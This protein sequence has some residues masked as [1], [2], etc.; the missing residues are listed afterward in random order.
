MNWIVCLT[1]ICLRS[2]F[3]FQQ[4]EIKI[5][6][7]FRECVVLSSTHIVSKSKLIVV[8][9]FKAY[10]LY[11]PPKKYCETNQAARTWWN[12]ET[13]D[14]EKASEIFGPVASRPVTRGVGNCPWKGGVCKAIAD[15]KMP[16]RFKFRLF[17]SQFLPKRIGPTQQVLRF[18]FIYVWISCWKSLTTTTSAR[19]S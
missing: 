10:D 2:F 18:F 14:N 16:E 19:H 12:T 4:W 5:Y 1:A 6:Q 13:H 3:Y 15:P 8:S 11:D 17:S 7:H 9:F